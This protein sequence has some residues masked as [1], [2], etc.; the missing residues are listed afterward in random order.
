MKRRMI[1]LVLALVLLVGLF[2]PVYAEELTAQ[3][4]LM[5]NIAAGYM[6]SGDE[7]TIMDMRAYAQVDGL[8]TRKISARAKQAY[9]DKAIQTLSQ[10]SV[11]ET[12]LSKTI[13]ALHALGVDAQELYPAQ[14][15]MPINA[16]QMLKQAEHA[17]SVWV[18]P[19]TLAVFNHGEYDTEQMEQELVAALLSSQ[20][21][22][23]SWNEYGAID[24][25]ANAICGLAFYYDTDEQVAQAL[26]AAVEF[27]SSQQKESGAFDGGWGENSNSTA[28]VII[29]LAALGIDA[30]SDERFIKNENSLTDALMS[31]ALENLSGFGYMDAQSSDAYST[32]QCFRALIAAQQVIDTDSAFNAYGLHTASLKAGYATGAETPSGGDP[33]PE[34][35]EQQTIKVRF[36]VQTADKTWVNALELD[37]PEGAS[38]K[39]A[40]DEA[41]REDEN[42][43]WS[44]SDNYVS[45][46][47]YGNETLREKDAG[48]KSG[49]KYKVNG[50]APLLS[51]DQCMLKQGDKV[52]LYFV[53]DYTL[54]DTPNG[55]MTWGGSEQTEEESAEEP[56]QKAAVFTDIAGHW[57]KTHI[58]T[59]YE[60]GLLLGVDKDTFMPDASMT[61]AMLVTVLHRMAGKPAVPQTTDFDDVSADSWYSKATAW[62]QDEGIVKGVAPGQ[63]GAE[64]TVTREQ[65]V[66]MLLRYARAMGYDTEARADLTA[67]ADVKQLGTDAHEAFAWAVAMGIVKGTDKQMLAPA[68]PTTR[69]QI[70]AVLARM[71]EKE[72]Q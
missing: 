25:T 51:I 56:S 58:Q 1:S 29:A 68:Q 45:A 57:A 17:Q 31:F 61:R 40:L 71:L 18:A 55:G 63:F 2:S 54:D 11:P 21:A 65:L 3:Q 22:D 43:Q 27:L 46:I 9:I 53:T 5:Q 64:A 8:A 30:A 34:G 66:L 69:A 35:P 59:V 20:N 14:G 49:W 62:A 7:W 39:D 32:E 48:A 10:E 70:A 44:G 15:S 52:V 67:F 60:K 36:S 12:T 37:L 28:T 6:Q 47:S 24:D 19:Y 4:Q 41:C 38:V 16:V 26:D 50:T 42:L 33:K 23:G 72:Q 13:L